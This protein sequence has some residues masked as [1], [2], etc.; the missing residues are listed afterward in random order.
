MMLRL[1]AEQSTTP[2]RNFLAPVYKK[3]GSHLLPI[4]G[5]SLRGMRS[6][7]L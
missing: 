7:N 3:T 6:D 1:C 4:L 5:C 2:T